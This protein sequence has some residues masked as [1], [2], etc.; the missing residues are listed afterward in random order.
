[1]W[2]NQVQEHVYHNIV[3]PV[4]EVLSGTDSSREGKYTGLTIKAAFERE[5]PNVYLVLDLK[6]HFG[7]VL[8]VIFTINLGFCHQT[9]R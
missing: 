5:G 2:D 4:V 7:V 6:N 1:M 3:I 8:T 9:Q